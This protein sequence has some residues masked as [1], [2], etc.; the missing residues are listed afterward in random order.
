MLEGYLPIKVY[1]GL[2]R[3][4]DLVEL[5]EIRFRLNNPVII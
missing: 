5:N 3:Y 1:N 2:K 4:F